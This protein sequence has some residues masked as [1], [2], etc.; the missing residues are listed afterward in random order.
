VSVTFASPTVPGGT[1]ATAVITISAPAGNAGFDVSLAI[2]STVA[3]LSSTA[4]TIGSGLTSTQVVVTTN[5]TATAQVATLTASARNDT[6]TANLTIAPPSIRTLA[7]LPTSIGNGESATAT[8]TLDGPAPSGGTVVSLS[9]NNRFVTMQSAD[10]VDAGQTT[11]TFA[12]TGTSVSTQTSVALTATAGGRSQSAS[13][14]VLPALRVASIGFQSPVRSGNFNSVRVTLTAPAPSGGAI[15]SLIVTGVTLFSGSNTF[16]DTVPAGQTAGSRQFVPPVTNTDRAFTVT[17]TLSGETLTRSDTLHGPL[18]AG[19]LLADSAVGGT[20]QTATLELN[21]LLAS[22]PLP[23]TV[24]S[25]KAAIDASRIT[26]FPNSRSVSTTI[27]TSA[28]PQ[29]TLVFLTFQLNGASAT[30][31]I[32]LLLPPPALATFTISPSSVRSGSTVTLTATLTAAA[33]SGGVRVAISSSATTLVGPFDL[34]VPGG[35][36]S[37]SAQIPTPSVIPATATITVTASFNG[38]SRSASLTIS[39]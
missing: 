5:P 38:V 2:T 39:P 32:K 28:V 26:F 36:T 24:Q 27:P 18:I 35:A 14:T 33:P 31:A 13:L 30:K 29:P 15:V 1:N 34:S 19:V 4:V 10:T 17:A 20:T 8:I 11:T 12:V 7:V 3:H 6:R 37:G 25:D 23:I 16:V 22:A 21:A 9:K